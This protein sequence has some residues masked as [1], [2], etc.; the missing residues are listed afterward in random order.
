MYVHMES[1]AWYRLHIYP[2]H[3][4][5]ADF[6][7]PKM[8]FIVTAIQTPTHGHIAGLHIKP[9]KTS[10]N[11]SIH[12]DLKR[13]RKAAT[14]NAALS[15]N[16]ASKR[17]RKWYRGAM[18]FLLFYYYCYFFCHYSL[19]IFDT[20]F[21]PWDSLFIYKK[22]LPPLPLTPLPPWPPPLFL[23]NP[24]SPPLPHLRPSL[25]FYVFTYFY[26][27]FFASSSPASVFFYH[28]LIPLTLFHL[29]SSIT[30]SSP[31]PPHLS[32][33]LPFVFFFF[34]LHHPLVPPLAF[35]SAI[36]PWKEEKISYWTAK[37]QRQVDH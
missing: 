16:A 33:L 15:Y 1:Y 17:K 34:P 3:R 20:H 14:D 9:V 19:N 2:K 30:H 10:D 32:P 8:I 7:S 27:V 26:F 4:R 18:L 5:V 37:P 12:F 13:Y 6:C 29:P 35:A 24:T 25:F 28:L 22:T 21:C 31:P 23:L 36:K 11:Y